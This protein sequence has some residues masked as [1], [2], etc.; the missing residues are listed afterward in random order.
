MRLISTVYPTSEDENAHFFA[1]HPTSI[2][3]DGNGQF[4]IET[5]YEKFHQKKLLSICES[6][7]TPLSYILKI[8][9][10]IQMSHQ[11]IKKNSFYSKL[12]TIQVF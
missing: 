4:F 6:Y 11:K 3:Q 5:K 9:D 12:Y 8:A 2:Y 1:S 10:V 7:F